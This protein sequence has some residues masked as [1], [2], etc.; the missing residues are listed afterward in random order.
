MGINSG[1]KGLKGVYLFGLVKKEELFVTSP[2]VNVFG[3][4]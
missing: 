1:F 2:I 3:I 4:E